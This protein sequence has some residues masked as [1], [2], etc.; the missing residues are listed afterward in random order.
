MS[1]TGIFNEIIKITLNLKK[2]SLQLLT[3]KNVTMTTVKIWSNY[4][5]YFIIVFNQN[6]LYFNS[7]N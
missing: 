3:D 5:I 2:A 6:T 4:I 1:P 7:I